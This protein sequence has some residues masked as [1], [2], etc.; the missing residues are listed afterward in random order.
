[1]AKPK[2]VSVWVDSIPGQ[3]ARIGEALAKA[4]INVTAFTA[5]GTG[6]ESPVRML[7]TSPAKA[8][9]VLREMDLRV[10]EEDVLRL[11]LPDKPGNLAEIAERLAQAH[12]NVDYSYAT[13][14][15][16]TKKSDLVLAVSDL[17]G[18]AKVLKGL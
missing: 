13:A 12:I 17:A 8:K 14:A 7:V 5:Y 10:T 3:I 1:M 16:G 4:K 15:K 18:A 11:T 2:Q 9:K 6:G